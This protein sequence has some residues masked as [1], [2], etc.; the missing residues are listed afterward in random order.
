M[1]ADPLFTCC[2][3]S[4]ICLQP[5]CKAGLHISFTQT[6]AC[7]GHPCCILALQ[8]SRQRLINVWK[9]Y[10]KSSLHCNLDDLLAS[11]GFT[12]ISFLPPIEIRYWSGLRSTAPPANICD[13]CMLFFPSLLFVLHCHFSEWKPDKPTAP[14][15]THTHTTS[16]S[17]PFA[18]RLHGHAEPTNGGAR[19]GQAGDLIS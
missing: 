11:F 5:L 9:S 13:I 12:G 8:R 15:L 16:S 18:A 14:P 6:W 2:F 4:P 1:Q 10:F 3:F 17:P 19:R 7:K